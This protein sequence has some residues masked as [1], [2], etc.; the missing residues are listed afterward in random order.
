M[1]NTREHGH[2]DHRNS[3]Q[4]GG[5]EKVQTQADRAHQL[6]EQRTG[7]AGDGKDADRHSRHLSAFWPVA[8]ARTLINGRSGVKDGGGEAEEQTR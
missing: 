5:T 7:L 4:A 1:A 6:A 3:D 2:D 8:Q